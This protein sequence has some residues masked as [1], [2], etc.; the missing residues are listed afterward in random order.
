MYAKLLFF[1]PLLP[2][3]PIVEATF[4]G[5]E[6]LTYDLSGRGDSFVSSKDKLTMYFKTR[7]ADGLLFYT[8][9]KHYF[10]FE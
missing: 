1:K 5:V 7:H 6:Y 10:H 4:T 9:N 8:G 2:E 3:K